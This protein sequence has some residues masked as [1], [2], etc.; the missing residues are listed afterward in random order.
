MARQT[1]QMTL[2]A[3]DIEGE[4]NVPL[5]EN[6]ARLSQAELVFSSS[7][8]C[9]DL[10]VPAS[11]PFESISGKFQTILACETGVKARNVFAYPAPRGKT[12]LVVGNE[13]VGIPRLV[14]KQCSATVT[15]PMQSKRLS[16]VNVAASSAIAL[17]VLERDLARRTG[18][19]DRHAGRRSLDLLMDAPGNPSECG[20]LLRSA[21][22][23][24]WKKVFLQDRMGSWFSD[25]REMVT[26]SRAAARRENNLIVI[27]KANTLIPNRY[28]KI[29]WCHGARKG[30]PLSHYRMDDCRNALLVYGSEELP[31]CLDTLPCDDVYVDFATKNTAA[32]PRHEASTL[33][34]VMA[35]QLQNLHHG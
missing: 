10:A 7:G 3:L 35:Q 6:A 12:A 5:L 25:D 27:L 22:A 30:E 2:I 4:W 20:S 33:L 1:N 32:R 15:I 31:E 29:V 18:I 8:E 23:F 34:S 28:E 26:Q 9:S 24:G 16:S 19:S 21:S 11:E 13:R 14:L 17:Y